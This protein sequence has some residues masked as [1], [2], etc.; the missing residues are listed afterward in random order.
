MFAPSALPTH[1]VVCLA[2]GGGVIDNLLGRVKIDP[3]EGN[4]G[5][6]QLVSP[7]E[8][9]WYEETPPFDH[10]LAYRIGKRV[11]TSKGSAGTWTHEYVLLSIEY[12]RFEA[13]PLR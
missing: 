13:R 8:D 5:F 11:V 1:R 4:L 6:E 12:V 3:G 9:G 10:V 2:R 7:T